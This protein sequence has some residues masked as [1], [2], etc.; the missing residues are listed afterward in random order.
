MGE[1]GRAVESAIDCGYRHIDCAWVYSN[2]NEVGDAIAKKIKE[3]IVK[4]GELFVTS[5][6]KRIYDFT[7]QRS[8]KQVYYFYLSGLIN[9]QVVVSARAG[10]GKLRPARAFCAARQHL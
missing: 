6:V 9:Y 5:K 1:V 10:V 8:C 4:R 7:L 3:N 2:E